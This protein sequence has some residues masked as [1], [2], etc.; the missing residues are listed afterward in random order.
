MEACST[1]NYCYKIHSCPSITLRRKKWSL[2]KPSCLKE[3]NTKNKRLSSIETLVPCK[4]FAGGTTTEGLDPILIHTDFTTHVINFISAP[5][6]NKTRNVLPTHAS[7]HKNWPKLDVLRSPKKAAPQ[8]SQPH[9]FEQQQRTEILEIIKKTLQL[10]NMC[11]THL[12]SYKLRYRIYVLIRKV[13]TAHFREERG[14]LHGFWG[15]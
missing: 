13:N 1:G 11:P 14:N 15:N 12:I 3:E 7:G 6:V 4:I 5:D 10:L 2:W 8:I 9:H